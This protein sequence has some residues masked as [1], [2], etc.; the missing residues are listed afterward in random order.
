MRVRSMGNVVI[1]ILVQGG[2]SVNRPDSLFANARKNVVQRGP[3]KP[4][5]PRPIR[6][7]PPQ[8]GFWLA[9]NATVNYRGQE[10]SQ[11]LIWGQEWRNGPPAT[12]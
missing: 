1:P 2:F 10:L 9:L 12:P 8:V 11:F 5:A 4:L 3:E 6:I 7:L